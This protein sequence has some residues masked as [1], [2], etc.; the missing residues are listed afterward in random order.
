MAVP[1]SDLTLYLPVVTAAARQAHRNGSTPA[2]AAAPPPA[3]QSAVRRQ[4]IP[5]WYRAGVGGPCCPS[6]CC[7]SPCCPG[8]A[9][10]WPVPCS[11]GARI[12]PR[13]AAPRRPP[14]C[15]RVRYPAPPFCAV[16]DQ[17]TRSSRGPLWGLGMILSAD[18]GQHRT[19][20]PGTAPDRTGV[21]VSARRGAAR[22]GRRASTGRAISGLGRDSKGW[23]S[24]G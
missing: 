8:P 6:P 9:Q 19:G 24:K 11:H 16:P 20:A 5:L 7:P 14:P 12:A 2:Q 3:L 4:L 17:R 21:A 23:D 22:C 18:R 13:R 10:I 15:D 1:S